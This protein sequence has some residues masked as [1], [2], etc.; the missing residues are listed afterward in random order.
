MEA[1]TLDWTAT[2]HSLLESSQ[3][4]FFLILISSAMYALPSYCHPIYI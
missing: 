4:I 3:V 2:F 1:I